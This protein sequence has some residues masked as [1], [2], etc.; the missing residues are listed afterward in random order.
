MASANSPRAGIRDVED[1]SG[2]IDKAS[3]PRVPGGRRRTTYYRKK[4]KEGIEKQS[5]SI[6]SEKDAK[7]LRPAGSILKGEMPTHLVRRRQSSVPHV[8]LNSKIETRNRRPALYNTCLPILE[9][10]PRMRTDAECQTMLEMLKNVRFLKPLSKEQQV[11]LCRVMRVQE[12]PFAG[13]DIVKQGEEGNSMF[14]ILLVATTCV[15]AI[16]M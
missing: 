9:R 6:G 14:I 7:P 10:E 11:N 12:V 3:I 2:V 4:E 8:N 16:A 5:E 1:F 13:E 15:P